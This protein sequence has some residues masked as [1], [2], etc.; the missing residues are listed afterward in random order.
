M[1]NLYLEQGFITSRAYIPPQDL[2]DGSLDLVVVEGVI[3]DFASSDN[4]ITAQ[5]LR[6][7]FPSQTG[8]VLNIRALEQGVENLNSVSRNNARL[9]LRPGSQ[10]GQTLV[11]VTNQQS[12][13][14]RGSVGVNNYGVPSTGEYQ[15]DGN[16]VVD[17]PL[18]YNDTAFVSA[19]SNVGGHDLPHAQ[20]RSYSASWSM[21]LGYWH[22]SFNNSYYEYEQTVVGDVTNFSI[23]GSSTNNALQLG[24]NIFR[25]QADKL[26]LTLGFTRKVSKNYIEDVFLETSS[27]TLYVWDL[28]ID[29]RRFLENGT[30]TLSAG[31]VKSVPW[32][33]AKRQLVAEE[34][35]FQFSKYHLTLGYNT[36]FDI[37][38]QRFFYNASA[39]FLYAPE[40]ILASEGITVGGRYS[41]RGLSQS[42]LFGY[43]GG[44]LRN[45]LSLPVPVNSAVVSQVQ[46]FAGLDAGWTNLPEYP[47]K[48]NDW[49]AGA[50]AGLKLLGN[51]FSLTFSYARA[52][53]VPDFL[54]QQQQEIDASVRF[55][56]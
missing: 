3:E 46:Y 9:D 14:W 27:R 31:A 21:P 42:S 33:D 49:V 35:N 7:A 50:I 8:E 13:G 28:T 52:L 6:L 36:Q 37:K 51:R 29:Y 43:R 44:Y 24:R 10:Q 41:V 47:E 4:S 25:S 23:S 56:F 15:L 26:D 1:S 17:N 2:S 39:D 32:F 40:V 48:Q 11:A 53:R 38:G 18:G 54:P 19:S 12:R 55:N 16:V 34:D 45:D 20:S 5:Q 30:F 22:F